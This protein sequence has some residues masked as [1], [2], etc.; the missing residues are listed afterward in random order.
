MPTETRT[1]FQLPLDH[2]LSA[3]M[4][5][6]PMSPV[7]TGEIDMDEYVEH[8]KKVNSAIEENGGVTIRETPGSDPLPVGSKRWYGVGGAKDVDTGQRYPEKITRGGINETLAH[9]MDVERGNINRKRAGWPAAHVGGWSE[10]GDTVLD[11]TSV[12]RSRNQALRMGQDRG[13]RAIFDAKNIE[14]V[15][16]PPKESTR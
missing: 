8:A 12:T 10:E 3:M 14:E 15:P 5:A 11:A 7:M 9:I 6:H 16:V 1:N 4:Y 2:P 13:E